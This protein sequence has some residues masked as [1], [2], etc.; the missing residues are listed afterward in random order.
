MAVIIEVRP[1]TTAGDERPLHRRTWIGSRSTPV[2]TLSMFFIM[3][4]SSLGKSS[5]RDFLR[6]RESAYLLKRSVQRI[7]NRETGVVLSSTPPFPS[8]LADLQESY[9]FICANVHQIWLPCWKSHSD[10]LNPFLGSVST[11]T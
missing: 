3:N 6:A 11:I 8:E 2:V 1:V 10:Q 4:L 9:E 5:Y 7:V